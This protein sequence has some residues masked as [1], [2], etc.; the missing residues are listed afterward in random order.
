MKKITLAAAVLAG[1]LSL[2][3]QT[4]AAH[5]AEAKAIWSG[6]K[7]NLQK[8]AEA[9][10][11][12]S[13]GFK[14]TPEIRS[15]GELISHIADAQGLFCSMAAGKPRPESVAKKT[16]KADLVAAMKDSIAL[17]D[18]AFD[19]LTEANASESV[20]Q[21]RMARSRLATLEYNSVHSSEEY[22]YTAVYLRLKGVV[23]PS[24]AGR[25]PGR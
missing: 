20:G 4:Q 2:H 24:S 5:I 17:C 15:F 9:M 25:G 7:G 18:A 3:A 21:G 19:S 13:Y 6:A 8:L 1:S 22:G 16:A 11:E 12:E 10:P 14:P 23:P